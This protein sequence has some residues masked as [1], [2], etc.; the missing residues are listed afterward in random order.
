MAGS[1]NTEFFEDSDISFLSENV[2]SPLIERE[3]RS[4]SLQLHERFIDENDA[5]NILSAFVQNIIDPLFRDF[6]K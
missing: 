6:S 4:Y 3:E 1:N 2:I 5:V